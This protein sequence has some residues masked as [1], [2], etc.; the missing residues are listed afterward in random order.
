M[1]HLENAF[2]FVFKNYIVAVPFFV[3]LAVP[4]LI[5]QSSTFLMTGLFQGLYSA[6]KDI[7]TLRN[8]FALVGVLAPLFIATGA[9]GVLGLLLRLAAMPVTAGMIKKGISGGTVKFDDAIPMAKKHF[10]QF[11]VYWVANIAVGIILGIVFIIP[12]AIFGALILILKGFG[13][14]LL[15]LVILAEIAAWIAVMTLLSLWL[16]AMIIDDMGVIDA[17]KKSVEI[18]KKN[19]WTILGITLLIAILGGIAASI[20]GAIF[21][22][23]PIIGAV[24]ATV[25]PALVE[26]LRMAFYFIYYRGETE[27]GVAV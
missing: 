8:P 17:A 4:A 9:A 5:G 12:V 16:P 10:V 1:K 25:V 7:D 15:I 22:F 21:G 18:V 3:A 27:P 20:V 26:V 23:I 2:S 13:V 11:L 6:F 14:F 19:F 24:I